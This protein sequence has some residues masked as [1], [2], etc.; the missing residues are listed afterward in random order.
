ME[1]D[2]GM[3]SENRDCL[4][5]AA[6]RFLTPFSFPRREMGSRHL[7]ISMVLIRVDLE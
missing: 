2:D 1:K 5:R 7:F 6:K 4:P 3:D